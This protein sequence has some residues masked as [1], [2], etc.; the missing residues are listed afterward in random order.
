[1]LKKK[2]ELFYTRVGPLVFIQKKRTLM[3]KK[4]ESASHRRGEGTTGD[5]KRGSITILSEGLRELLLGGEEGGRT[6]G[7]YLEK[8]KEEISSAVKKASPLKKG[9]RPRGTRIVSREGGGESGVRKKK[10]VV[11][12]RL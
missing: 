1:L 5:A 6:R 7:A 9:S 10:A 2:G 3:A 12:L 11:A 4:R 8:D